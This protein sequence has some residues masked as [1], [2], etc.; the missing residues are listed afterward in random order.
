MDNDNQLLVS[1][2]YRKVSKQEEEIENLK[3][4][5]KKLYRLNGRIKNQQQRVQK[6]LIPKWGIGA[7]FLI[8]IFFESLIKFIARQSGLI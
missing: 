4:E 8:A 2:L 7:G 6:N 3:C 1:I 5:L